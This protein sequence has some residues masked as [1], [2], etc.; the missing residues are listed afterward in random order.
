MGQ[1]VEPGRSGVKAVENAAENEKGEK[2]REQIIGVLSEA[3]GA[4][5][6]GQSQQR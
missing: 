1:Q 4:A 3:Q 2:H 6:N 5:E